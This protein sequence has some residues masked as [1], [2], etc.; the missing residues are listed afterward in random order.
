MTPFAPRIVLDV[1]Y[2]TLINHEIHFSRQA[3]YLVK[4]EDDAHCTGRFMFGQDQ[5]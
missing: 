2:V 4:L 1:S 5:S 3:Q